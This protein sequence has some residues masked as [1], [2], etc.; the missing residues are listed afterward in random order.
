[1]RLSRDSLSVVAANARAHAL[2]GTI[3]GINVTAS[4]RRRTDVSP[5]PQRW[6]EWKRNLNPRGA[7][8]FRKRTEYQRLTLLA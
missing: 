3:A 5:A 7:A 1:M 6:V 8:E 4:P 2:A